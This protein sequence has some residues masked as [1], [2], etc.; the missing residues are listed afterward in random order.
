MKKFIIILVIS[1]SILISSTLPKAADAPKILL[2]MP[3][4][5]NPEN[6]DTVL[7]KEVSV[8]KSMLEKANFKVVAATI[9]GLPIKGSTE[10]F[11]PNLKLSDVKIDSYSGVIIA[12]MA[13]GESTPVSPLAVSVVKQALTQGKPVAASHSS[14]NVLAEAG[15]LAGKRYSFRYDPQ[16]RYSSFTG[17]IYSGMGVVQDGNIV[18]CGICPQVSEGQGFPDCTVELI[19]A[20]ITALTPKK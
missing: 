17:A 6:L 2:I 9:D 8:M 15:V 20:F 12:C 11:T 19:Q 10:T 7:K 5:I 3:N 13:S 18:T 16:I 14:V 1:L 4:V